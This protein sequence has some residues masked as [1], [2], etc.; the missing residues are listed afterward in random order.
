MA[1]AGSVLL[2]L[3]GAFGVAGTAWSG[4]G[5]FHVDPEL[6]SVRFT[7]LELGFSKQEGRLG[8]TSGAIVL[9]ERHKVESID[10][11]IETASVDTGWS[12]RDAFLRSE[13][14]F[15]AARFPRLHFHSTGFRY[16][17]TRLTG[18]DG[19]VTLRDVTRRVH[20]DVTRLECVIRPGDEKESCG[21]EVSGR[22]SRAA[23]GMGFAYPLIGDEVALEF[24]VK[25]FRPLP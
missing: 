15:D 14:M 25:A 9:D 4:A 7:V 3:L 23:F 1:R 11:E 18:V 8:C 6:T 2:C 10:L 17:G 12:L 16:E 19:E 13:V 5:A 20:F 22:I 21:A 24:V